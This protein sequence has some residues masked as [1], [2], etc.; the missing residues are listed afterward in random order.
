MK[1]K[2]PPI[3][4][5]VPAQPVKASKPQVATDWVHEIKHDG[6]QMIVCRDG[7]SVRLYSRNAYGWTVRLAAIVTAA[8]QI[9]AK[10]FT[11]DGEAV[12]LRPDGLSRFEEL[13]HR[14]GVAAPLA[15]G[16]LGA[17]LGTPSSL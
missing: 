3:G 6:Y 8:E 17:F 7:P 13:S 1:T 16:H 5:V 14:E 11:I 4:F 9:K 10:N 12:V 2:P 15:D